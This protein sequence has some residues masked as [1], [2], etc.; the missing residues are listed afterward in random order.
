MEFNLASIWTG[1]MEQSRKLSPCLPNLHGRTLLE[2]I[3]FSVA[4]FESNC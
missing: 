1:M 3:I 4:Y 2:T